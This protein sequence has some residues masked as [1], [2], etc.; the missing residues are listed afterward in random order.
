M[1][2]NM[3]ADK[4][5]ILTFLE[6]RS[7]T[8]VVPVYQRNY[9]WQKKQCEKLFKDIENIIMNNFESNHFIGT[10]VYIDGVKKFFYQDCII[11]D[12]QQRITTIM[13]L[14][15]AIFDISNELNED[16]GSLKNNIKEW[17]LL[18]KD[19]EDDNIKLKLCKDDFNNWKNLLHNKIDEINK[20]SDIY[21]NYKL[22]I[23]LL[24]K[25]KFSINEIFDAMCKLEVVYIMLEKSEAPQLIFESLNSTG[26]S[27]TQGDLIRNYLLMNQEYKKQEKLYIDYWYKIEKAIGNSAI[28]HFISSYIAMKTGKVEKD[29]ELYF[30]F[31]EFKVDK[32]KK[33]PNL[34]EEYFLEELLT[35]SKYYEWFIKQNC[36]YENINKFLKDI[37]TLNYTVV[38]PALLY[39]FE[40]TFDYKNI[41][42]E[43][44]EELLN[45]IVTYLI[46]RMIC[47]YPTNALKNNFSG[48]PYKFEELK[49]GTY[50]EKLISILVKD[51]NNSEFPKNKQFKECFKKYKFYSSSKTRLCRYILFEIEN[52]KNK[53]E[54]LINSEDI[55]IEHIMPQKLTPSWKVSLGKDVEQI[56]NEYLD[57]IGNLSLTGYNGNL[58]NK[59]F[60][61]KK[62]YFEKS[63]FTITRELCKFENWDKNSIENRAK[64]F[65][66]IA[67]QIWF[68]DEKYNKDYEK[69][70]INQ[71]YLLEENLN[72]TNTKPKNIIID[73]KIYAI[74]S[75]REFLKTLTKYFY[76]LDRHIFRDFIYDKDFTGNT[77]KLIDITDNKMNEPFELDSSLFIEI[78]LSAN[79]TLNLCK[80]I[81]E[82]YDYIDKIS[83]NLRN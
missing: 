28:T 36:P 1:E 44:L 29:D 39:F 14:L 61:D 60:S 56:H 81:A 47:K 4:I 3:K 64:E 5:E 27:L 22:F 83:F 49:Y 41:S 25:S 66:I 70:N 72:I 11:I 33:E 35:Y 57:T 37:N 13:L 34:D 30:K 2:E 68:L 46:R 58:S 69:L 40:E 78:N 52:F 38:Y 48:I 21:L 71:E 10:I 24:Q 74:K 73:D 7:K 54:V 63:N 79:A 76:D 75:W 53:K 9:S 50:K 55:Q 32:I 17:Y 15:K 43:E 80:L 23:S 82:K 18:H 20:A 42:L 19:K 65:S 59:N 6:N 16:K 77:K 26:L 8:F 62:D 51:I 45:I 67:E 31:K 12:G